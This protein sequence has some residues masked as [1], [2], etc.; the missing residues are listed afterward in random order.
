MQKFKI[1]ATSANLGPGFDT[2]GLALNLFNDFEVSRRKDNKINLSIISENKKILFNDSDNLIL[3]SYKS[4][5]KYIDRKVDG[6]NIIEKM[7]SPLAR[8]MG[9]SA[10]AI[11][12][13]LLAAAWN[14]KEIIDEKSFTKL[15]VDI[16]GHPDNVIPAIL[17]GLIINYKNNNSF[18][19]HKIEIPEEL[20][21]IVIVPNFELK[22]SE[23]RKVLPKK[24]NYSSAV[25]NVGRI[26]LFIASFLEKKYELLSEAM[27]DKLHQPYR[28]K[29]IPA[30][31]E[32]IKS[33]QISG[34]YGASLSGAGPTIIAITDKN[35]NEI[36]D[37]MI[38]V[39][40]K[41][42]VDAKKYILKGH[43][44]SLYK[45]IKEVIHYD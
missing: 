29:L 6:I 38:N 32:V 27:Q 40:A 20:K 37:N 45:N 42:N 19:Y 36:A 21:F 26:S 16:E 14:S 39:F 41:N 33:A 23:S 5:Y 18:S 7:N 17:G 35:E 44:G 11:V 3:K 25:F 30:F 12:G 9:S 22:T 24:L 34:A 31:D 4:Y 2:L 13:G 1:P 10:S 15:A 8:G 43:N 28:S